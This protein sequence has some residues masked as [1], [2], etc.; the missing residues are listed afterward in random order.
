MGNTPQPT[1]EPKPLDSHASGPGAGKVTTLDSLAS[2][3]GADD[4]T[5]LDSHASGEQ[6]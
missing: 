5:T 6:P 1:D 2:G 3:P 4:V